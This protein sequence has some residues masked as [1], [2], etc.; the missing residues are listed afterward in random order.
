MLLSVEAEQLLLT[1]NHGLDVD[2]PTPNLKQVFQGLLRVVNAQIDA[3]MPVLEQ[4]FAAIFKISIDGVD[5]RLTEVG[6]SREQLLFYAFPIPVGDLVDAPFR[7]EG[8]NEKF[9]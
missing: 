5:K 7:I 6:Q 9:V 8:I 4:Q 3:F 1:L 2:R